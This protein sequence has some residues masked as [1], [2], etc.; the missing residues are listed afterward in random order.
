MDGWMDGWII[1]YYYVL[2]DNVSSAL[3]ALLNQALDPSLFRDTHIYFSTTTTY[4]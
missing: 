1:Y 3:T 4:I 2:E